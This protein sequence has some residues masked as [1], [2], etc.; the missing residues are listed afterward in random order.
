[1]GLF[2]DAVAFERECVE[3]IALVLLTNIQATARLA[4]AHDQRARPV[5][6]C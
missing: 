3:T 2:C 1:M 5:L 6:V 4:R